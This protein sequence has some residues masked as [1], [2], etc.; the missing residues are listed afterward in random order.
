MIQGRK[1]RAEASL[2]T[3]LSHCASA[4]LSPQRKPVLQVPPPTSSILGTIRSQAVSE[5]V[6]IMSSPTFCAHLYSICDPSLNNTVPKAHYTF[7]KFPLI[8]WI[9][10]LRLLG[11]FSAEEGTY[12]AG[13]GPWLGYQT[14]VISN[15]LIESWSQW[16]FDGPDLLIKSYKYISYLSEWCCIQYWMNCFSFFFFLS[17]F[18]YFFMFLT[19]LTFFFLKVRRQLLIFLAAC[20][21]ACFTP[22]WSLTINQ[23]LKPSG[24]ATRNSFNTITSFIFLC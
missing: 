17:W 19:K 12:P 9:C 10:Y 5:T 21:S 23:Y 4:C 16:C 8:G 13:C 24:Q 15:S 18:L 6:I 3:S 20:S 2:C 22:L 11:D 14:M 7:N 1:F